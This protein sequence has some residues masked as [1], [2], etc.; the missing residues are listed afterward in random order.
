M[1]RKDKQIDNAKKY[2]L[3]RGYDYD[4]LTFEQ[5]RVVMGFVNSK[6]NA[7]MGVILISFAFLLTCFAAYTG[8]RAVGGGMHFLNSKDIIFYAVVAEEYERFVEPRQVQQ[9][10][11]KMIETSQTNGIRLGIAFFL[12]AAVLAAVVQQREK[13]RVIEAF[14]PEKEAEDDDLW[15]HN[16]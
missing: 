1:K 14:F 5:K 11:D 15:S 12:L 13:S 2:L 8:F 3:Q 4:R 16:K 6:T 10:A 7:R 9:L